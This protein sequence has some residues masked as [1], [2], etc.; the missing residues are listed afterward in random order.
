MRV[1]LCYDFGPLVIFIGRAPEHDAEWS[2]ERQCDE[3]KAF[4]LYAGKWLFVVS[5]RM[6]TR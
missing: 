6:R 5:P 1:N 3:P 4:T 2:M